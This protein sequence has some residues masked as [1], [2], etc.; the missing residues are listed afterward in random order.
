MS[1]RSPVASATRARRR[2]TR[3][4]LGCTMIAA[5]VLPAAASAHGLSGKQDLPIPRWL[6]AWAASIVLVASFI[7]LAALWAKPRLQAVRERPILTAPRALE[8][9]AGILGVA[10]FAVVVYAGY[11]GAQVATGN[12][13]PTVIYVVFWVGIP[14]AS[15]VFG[16]VFR[17]FNPWLAIGKASGWVARRLGGGTVPE[18]VAY[19]PSLGRW[20]AV[21]GVVIFAWVELVYAN[22]DQPSQLATMAVAY[23]AVQLL[24]MSLFGAET[25]S[26]RGDAFGVYFGLFARVA[27]LRWKERTLYRRPVLSGAPRLVPV[28]G[29]VALLCAMIGTTSFDGFSQGAAWTELVPHVQ[30]LFEH[31]GLNAEH[32]LEAA[33]TAGMVAMILLIAGLYRLGALGVAT[34][35]A[36]RVSRD[37]AA[38]RFAHTLIPIALAYVIAHYFSLLAYQGQAMGYLISDPLGHG[39]NLFGTGSAAINYTWIGMTGIWYVQVL[40]LVLGHVGGLTLAHDHALAL[41]PRMREATRSQYWMLAVMVTFTSLGL[42]LLSE[43]V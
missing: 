38:Q 39:A 26:R 41:F 2:R 40:A 1:P 24:A 31:L 22:R 11:A 27:P 15:A 8:L 10:A 14:F 29:T 9:L 3:R 32:A 12:L 16:D 5:L 28:A 37:V 43:A 7:G 35:D 23:A 19:P 36:R 13:A 42:W 17:A 25:W 6:F 18:P 34:V 33:G 4:A 30:S 21:A 20:P